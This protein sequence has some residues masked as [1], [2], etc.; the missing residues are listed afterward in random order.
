MRRLGLLMFL[1]LAAAATIAACGGVSNGTP[2]G[3][4]LSGAT[5]VVTVNGASQ[6]VVANGGYTATVNLPAP[7]NGGNGTVL[8]GL[9]TMPPRGVQPVAALYRAPLSVGTTLTAFAYVSITP[10]VTLTFPAIPNLTF[11]LPPSIVPPSGTNAAFIGFYDPAVS[12]TPTGWITVLGPGTVNGQAIAFQAYDG[13]VTLNGGST[14]VF[15][16]FSSVETPLISA[17]QR[18]VY[19]A[20]PS[21]FTVTALGAPSNTVTVLRLDGKD[22]NVNPMMV[23]VAKPTVAD[24]TCSRFFQYQT[25]PQPPKIVQATVVQTQPYSRSLPKCALNFTNVTDSNQFI[26]ISI[27]AL[28]PPTMLVSPSA[29][30]PGYGSNYAATILVSESNNAAPNITNMSF[31]ACNNYFSAT[32]GT[33][34]PNGSAVPIGVYQIPQATEAT[35]TAPPSCSPASLTIADATSA[36]SAPIVVNTAAPTMFTLTP[37]TA[38]FNGVGSNYAVTLTATDSNAQFT[39]GGATTAPSPPSGSPTACPYSYSVTNGQSTLLN[40]YLTQPVAGTCVFTV[41]DKFSESS[42]SVTLTLPTANV[43]IGGQ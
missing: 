6:A 28:A 25:N 7:S 9:D 41:T 4:G 15:A 24:T 5:S 42:Q 14:Y 32:L 29:V 30:T 23:T 3:A 22:I 8:I 12:P 38:T 27:D 40:V 19:G 10:S 2:A 11:T 36:T 33:P 16:L 26:A 34:M 21:K 13:P 1:A 31:G 35:S 17:A 39:F 20:T 18:A 37:A 43:T